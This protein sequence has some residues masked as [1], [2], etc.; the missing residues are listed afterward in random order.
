[1]HKKVNTNSRS[2]GNNLNYFYNNIPLAVPIDFLKQYFCLEHCPN[3]SLNTHMLFMK[4]YVITLGRVVT[5]KS[6]EKYIYPTPFHNCVCIFKI[7]MHIKLIEPWI[8][9]EG[10]FQKW[11]HLAPYIFT[12]YPVHWGTYSFH[13][14][15]SDGTLNQFDKLC[16]FGI[17]KGDTV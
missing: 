6:H 16:F 1:M 2:P 4:S 5:G 3:S 13:I 9:S 14:L 12:C 15:Q 7:G 17:R 11:F 8:L 10:S